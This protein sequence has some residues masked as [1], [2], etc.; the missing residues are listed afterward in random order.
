[1]CSFAGHDLVLLSVK[2]EAR[3]RGPPKNPT[4]TPPPPSRLHT[5]EGDR[6][7]PPPRTYSSLV[8]YGDP[9]T[10][11][12]D[13]HPPPSLPRIPAPFLV[14]SRG[15]GSFGSFLELQ[16][17]D[18]SLYTIPYVLVLSANLAHEGVQWSV[19]CGP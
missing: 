15:F 11:P 18:T 7:L 2:C 6:R 5:P 4:T 14:R 9:G 1:M 16:L 12:P 10:S 19:E 8:M 3:P 13:A 17:R